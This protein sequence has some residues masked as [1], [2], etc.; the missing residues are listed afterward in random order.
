MLMLKVELRVQDEPGWIRRQPALHAS[1][2]VSV[3]QK[4]V[5]DHSP[6]RPQSALPHHVSNKCKGVDTIR[7]TQ[8]AQKICQFQD[9]TAT[10]Q[11]GCIVRR[12]REPLVATFPGQNCP[13]TLMACL[14]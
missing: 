4:P 9:S 12:H 11:I 5:K 6:K 14:Q 8:D 3:V 1:C 10:D 7:S 2:I 13:D